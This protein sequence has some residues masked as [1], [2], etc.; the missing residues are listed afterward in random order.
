MTYEGR[1]RSGDSPESVT[2]FAPYPSFERFVEYTF[3]R[4]P[5]RQ[6]AKAAKDTVTQLESELTAFNGH[7]VEQL[8]PRLRGGQVG[9]VAEQFLLCLK[10][11]IVMNQD[12][13]VCAA[14]VRLLAPRKL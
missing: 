3:G 1:C 6:P 8:L 13:P 14:V 11:E 5:H 9:D 7:D 12:L 2:I 4:V 10:L